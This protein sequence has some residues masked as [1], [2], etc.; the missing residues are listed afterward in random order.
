M[1]DRICNGKLMTPNQKTLHHS[2]VSA[3]Q[4]KEGNLNEALSSVEGFVWLR[5]DT[6]VLHASQDN[7]SGTRKS[8]ERMCRLLITVDCQAP[9]W[10][11][12]RLLLS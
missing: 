3:L 6:L 5:N 12:R 7:L 9:T 2:E 4:A 8:L 1:F 10:E 11:W